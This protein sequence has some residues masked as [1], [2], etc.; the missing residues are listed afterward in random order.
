MAGFMWKGKKNWRDQAKKVV[1]QLKAAVQVDR[2]V[3]GEGDVRWYKR[4]PRNTRPG[5]N[6]N[7]FRAA[8]ALDDAL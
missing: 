8:T 7:A 4:L 2:V 3:L 5:N 6:A 1:E